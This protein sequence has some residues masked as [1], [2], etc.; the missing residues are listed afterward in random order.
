MRVFLLLW[1][2]TP[3]LSGAYSDLI[4]TS[5]GNAVYFQVQ[6]G[7]VTYSWYVA[8]AG[9]PGPVVTAVNQ[10]LADVDGGVVSPVAVDVARRNGADIVIAVGRRRRFKA[11]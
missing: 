2:L 3:P 4:A 5:D 7:P 10:P 9:T 8:R 11:R 1:F 6:T